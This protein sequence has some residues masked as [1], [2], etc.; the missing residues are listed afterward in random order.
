MSH[1]NAQGIAV[2]TGA[3]A[4]LGAVYADRLARRGY[5]LLLVARNKS[6]LDTVAAKI[7]ENTGR[8]VEYWP[9]TSPTPPNSRRWK[10]A[11][12]PTSRSR[13]W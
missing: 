13:C 9:P 1:T 10:P 7:T 3:S 8:T 11:Y 4:G 6:R 2:V 5:D 12:A